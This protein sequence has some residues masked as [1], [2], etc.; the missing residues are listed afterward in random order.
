M[1]FETRHEA[2]VWADIQKLEFSSIFG[3]LDPTDVPEIAVMRSAWVDL[4]DYIRAY[5]GEKFEGVESFPSSNWLVVP[6]SIAGQTLYDVGKKI[7]GAALRGAL[8]AADVPVD[9]IDW[10]NTDTLAGIQ[11]YQIEAYK[12]R[13]SNRVSI[14]NSL[15]SGASD[16]DIHVEGLRTQVLEL[17]SQV[18]RVSALASAGAETTEQRLKSLAESIEEESANAVAKT[19]S[20]QAQVE[21][22]SSVSQIALKE[23][24]KHLDETMND[25]ARR[26]NDWI[27]AQK[28]SAKLS[29][30]V[31]L[32]NSRSASHEENSRGL[33]KVALLSGIAGTVITPFVAWL[34]FLGA[35]TV[36]FDATL[37]RAEEVKTATAGIRPTLHFELIF[38][39][40]TTLFWLTMFFWLM[41]LLV[42]RYTGEQRMG[43][44]AS[45]RSAMAE[46]YVGFVA[47][48][49]AGEKE[50]PIVV[51]ALFRPV[52]ADGKG[53]DGPPTISVPAAFS[54]LL[55]GKG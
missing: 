14:G 39:A 33:G 46:T 6:Q 41:R 38:A 5:H 15:N 18:S 47:E 12:R 55:Q 42:K 36:L 32:W 28:Q 44:D 23:Y 8:Y 2:L 7:G 30:P 54:S 9:D 35:K 52:T 10:S 17:S 25:T 19:R 34:S 16:L 49:A 24:E 29:T 13:Q 3:S 26:L 20:A 1:R 31:E 27:E 37:G 45:G 51:E 21:S 40:T 53:D 50:R 11:A 43:I 4:V 48:G 22:M